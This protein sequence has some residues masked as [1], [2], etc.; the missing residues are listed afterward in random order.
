MLRKITV[1]DLARE[2]VEH[3]RTKGIYEKILGDSKQV[4]ALKSFVNDL[5][6]KRQASGVESKEDFGPLSFPENAELLKIMDVSDLTIPLF[7]NISTLFFKTADYVFLS[8]HNYFLLLNKEYFPREQFK[9]EE[10]LILLEKNLDYTY[11]LIKIF[12][13]L[14]E[15]NLLTAE[16]YQQVLKSKEDPDDYMH[17]INLLR[18]FELIKTQYKDDA[19]KIFESID[20]ENL[21]KYAGLI[22]SLRSEIPLRTER[23]EFE[24]D[25]K[26]PEPLFF[27]I[28]KQ[29]EFIK[30]LL[31]ARAKLQHGDNKSKIFYKLCETPRHALILVDPITKMTR[32]IMNWSKVNSSEDEVIQ[33]LC[34]NPE[35]AQEIADAIHLL[36]EAKPSQKMFRRAMSWRSEVPSLLTPQVFQVIKTQPQYAKGLQEGLTWLLNDEIS[37]F[38]DPGLPDMLTEMNIDLL[39]RN[40]KYAYELARSL[41]EHYRCKIYSSIS[42]YMLERYPEHSSLLTE[43]IFRIHKVPQADTLENYDILGENIAHIK[44]IVDLMKQLASIGCLTPGSLASVIKHAEHAEKIAKIMAIDDS[45]FRDSKVWKANF[46]LLTQSIPLLDEIYVALKGRKDKLKSSFKPADTIQN[47]INFELFSKGIDSSKDSTIHRFFG[48]HKDAK[49]QPVNNHRLAS[50]DVVNVVKRFLV[51]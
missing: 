18:F 34:D 30:D 14:D 25:L 31:K 13:F 47:V 32:S 3:D 11:T 21:C 4:K 20:F 29:A 8:K 6:L 43:F 12:K 2:L 49:D 33:L 46:I 16:R 7:K 50:P 40:P 23:D 48:V 22:L 28:I 35:Q 9:T 36:A 10:N 51:G 24:Y 26:M 37:M 44:G 17:F 42:I 19:Q 15:L 41:R 39:C 45:Y 5:K 1:E 38:W 27:Q